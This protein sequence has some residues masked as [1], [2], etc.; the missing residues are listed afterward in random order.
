MGV[1]TADGCED[2][3]ASG[4]SLLGWASG[5]A[6][7]RNGCCRVQAVAGL[8]A[9]AAPEDARRNRCAGARVRR[10]PTAHGGLCPFSDLRLGPRGSR[11]GRDRPSFI[12]E[13]AFIQI[14][15]SH[16]VRFKM[17]RASLI[18]IHSR[19]DFDIIADR[20][21]GGT[22]ARST[23][24]NVNAKMYLA[25]GVSFSCCIHDLARRCRHSER[26]ISLASRSNC[27]FGTTVRVASRWRRLTRQT[28]TSLPPTSSRPH[29][30][31][32]YRCA[33]SFHIALLNREDDIDPIVVG[34][35]GVV[36][37]EV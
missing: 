33:L 11:R 5:F 24:R 6:P 9:K 34:V 27:R 14:G 10:S 28:R 2:A 20:G 31:R 32:K 25:Y 36:R 12:G 4:A 7:Q 8:Q 26:A 37:E 19:I 30:P 29:R 18:I 35:V 15:G 21:Q 1:L 3:G 17:S 13:A 16:L 22:V 23:R